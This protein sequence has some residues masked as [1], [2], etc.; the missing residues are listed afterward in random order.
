MLVTPPKFKKH[1]EYLGKT[2]YKR[3]ANT[4]TS[5]GLWMVDSVMYQ[6]LDRAKK[7]IEFYNQQP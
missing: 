2:I 6:T 5:G 1:S 4:G 3:V 7:A